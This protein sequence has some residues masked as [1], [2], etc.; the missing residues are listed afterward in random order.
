MIVIKSRDEIE[1]IRESS[2]IVAEVLQTLREFIR[3]GITTWALNK[4][5]E[6]VIKK[7][8]ARAAFKGYKPSFGSG[9]YPAA[10]CV[11]INEEV[12]H[13]IPSTRRVIKEGD[14]VS[15]DVGVCYKGYYG[16]GATTVAV[17]KVEDRVKELLKVAEEALYRGIEAARVGNRVGDISFAVQS[18]VESHGFSVIREFVGH[19]VGKRIHEEPPVPNFGEPGRG[20][21]LKEGMTIAIEPMVAMGSGE[22]RIKEDGWTA[23]TVDGSWAAHFEHTIAVLEEGPRILTEL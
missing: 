14:I 11:S 21:L 20:P 3:P 6:E 7:R 12:I 19:G 9:A 18:H 5:A 1:K 13:G 4:K 23:V 16:D 22:V 2:R 10:L 15:M 8:K 17:G